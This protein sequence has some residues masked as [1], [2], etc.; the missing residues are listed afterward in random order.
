MRKFEAW[1]AMA[2]VALLGATAVAQDCCDHCGCNCHVQKVCRLKCETKKVP[3]T[4]YTCECEDFCIPGVSKKCGCTCECDECGHEHCKPNWVPQCAK[5]HTRTKLIKKVTEKEEK[6]YK[7]V[8]EYVCDQCA[9][10]CEA[11]TQDAAD[12]SASYDGG[13][14]EVNSA[15]DGAFSQPLPPRPVR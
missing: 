1:M 3:K 7:W 15:A 8:V 5:V 6:A 12:P 2:I 9:A 14:H 10:K 11:C 4:T 13:P